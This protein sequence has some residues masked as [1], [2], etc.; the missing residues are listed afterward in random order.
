M[1]AFRSLEFARFSSWPIENLERFVVSCCEQYLV[2]LSNDS[3]A[4]RKMLKMVEL[5]DF[6][7]FPLVNPISM[8]TSMK[9]IAPIGAM[10]PELIFRL[11]G[12]NTPGAVVNFMRVVQPVMRRLFKTWFPDKCNEGQMARDEGKFVAIP[13]GDWDWVAKTGFG[14]LAAWARAVT[15]PATGVVSAGLMC[16]AHAELASGEQRAWR[17]AGTCRRIYAVVFDPAG[18]PQVCETKSGV[19]SGP[20]HLLLVADNVGAWRAASAELVMQ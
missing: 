14:A 9:H 16:V 17:L 13:V 6:L 4:Q 2:V 10:Y 20:G 12:V 19:A 3:L 18:R 8:A 1:I 15:L 7:G 11:V 5:R